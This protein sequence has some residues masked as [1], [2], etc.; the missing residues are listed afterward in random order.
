MFSQ[1]FSR[2]KEE[3][4]WFIVFFTFCGITTSTMADCKLPTCCQLA[5]GIPETLTGAGQPQHTPGR[6]FSL[7]LFVI[8]SPCFWWTECIVRAATGFLQVSPFSTGDQSEVLGQVGGGGMPSLLLSHPHGT[9]FSWLWAQSE[10][11]LTISGETFLRVLIVPS[12]GL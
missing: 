6:K 2:K 7:F 9:V 8:Q 3:S 10:H 5:C 4:F 11:T 1:G 12:W